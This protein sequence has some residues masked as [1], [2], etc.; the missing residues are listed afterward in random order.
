MIQC[1][2]ALVKSSNEVGLKSDRS[3]NQNSALISTVVMRLQFKMAYCSRAISFWFPPH[4]DM[5]S[6][7]AFTVATL[8]S[9]PAYAELVIT[10]TGLG[11]MK[12]S[13]NVSKC[14]ICRAHRPE[15][16]QE[17]MLPR[18]VP[19]RPWS[20]VAVDLLQLQNK[21]YLITVD[22]DNGFLKLTACNH[23]AHLP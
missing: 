17:P 8:A 4:W 21:E 23:H 11:W 9:K 16:G 20:K 10:C 15:Q 12:K 18:S 13:D 5:M 3:W 2:R 22:K 19:D 1:C 6:C 7:S 14:V